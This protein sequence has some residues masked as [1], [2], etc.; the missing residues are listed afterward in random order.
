MRNH[1]VVEKISR[2]IQKGIDWTTGGNLAFGFVTTKK[3]SGIDL[4][5]L[6]YESLQSSVSVMMM[7]DDG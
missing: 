3:Y 6:H 7:M 4:I 1:V 5:L 2:T